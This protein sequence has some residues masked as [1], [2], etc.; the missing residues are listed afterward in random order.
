MPTLRNIPISI[1]DLPTH[2]QV[3]IRPQSGGRTPDAT[4][5]I[6]NT[7]ARRGAEWYEK[8]QICLHDSGVRIADAHALTDPADLPEAV[9]TAVRRGIK[10]VVVGGGDGTLRSVADHLA[11]TDVTLGVLPLGTVNDLARNLGIKPEVEA[12]CRVIADGHTARIDVGQANGDLFLLT[13]SVGFSVQSQTALKPELKKRFGPFGYLVASLLALRGLRKMRVRVS[14]EGVTE[15]YPVLQAGVIKGH[16]WMG[17]R[18]QIP[19]INLEAGCLAYYALFPQPGLSYLR[20]VN[21]LLRGQ[22]FH[23]PGL[24]SFTAR[25]VTIETPMPEPLVLDG[26]LCGHTPVRMR[27]L[28]EALRV[29]VPIGFPDICDDGSLDQQH[30]QRKQGQ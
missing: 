2:N 30:R 6:V 22:F 8:A 24:R 28:P 23:T 9:R 25:E 13:A 11:N 10:R 1:T 21:R 15:E 27:V 4:S 3:P 12:A 29:F 18:C 5:L 7:R 26:D 20:I 17:G 14:S 19:G 16:E